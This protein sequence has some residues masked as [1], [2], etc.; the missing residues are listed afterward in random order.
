MRDLRKEYAQ[1]IQAERNHLAE[2]LPRMARAAMRSKYR[3]EQKAY[4]KALARYNSLSSGYDSARSIEIEDLPN[5]GW[6]QPDSMGS[7][8][9]YF[10]YLDKGFIIHAFCKIR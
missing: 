9:L 2:Q 6:I 10:L 7:E 3:T 5:L 1:Q 4:D 8:N